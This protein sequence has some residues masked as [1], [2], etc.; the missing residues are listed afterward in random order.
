MSP[1]DND[2]VFIDY[3]AGAPTPHV[4]YAARLPL[5]GVTFC[6]SIFPPNPGV[7]LGSTQTI[8][9]VHGPPSFEMV[10]HDPERDGPRQQIVDP[11]Q[12]NINRSCLPVFHRWGVTA[13]ALIIALDDCLIARTV[14]EAFDCSPQPMRVVVG[15]SDPVI[16]EIAALSDR[17]ISNRGS[18]G[19]LYA[20]SLA[21]ALIIHLFRSYGMKPDP[22]RLVR[23]GLPAVQLRR[24]RDYVDAHLGE[25][26]GLGELAAL[27]G[28]SPHHFGQAFKASTGQPPHQYVIDRRVQRAKDLLIAGNLSIAEIAL[29]VGFSNQ[30]HMTFNFRKRIGTTPAHYRRDLGRTSI[31]ILPAVGR[32]GLSPGEDLASPDGQPVLT[33]ANV[34]CP[35]DTDQ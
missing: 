5:G 22:L 1:N 18:F 7:T 21:T 30:S 26:I 9:A 33:C 27:A 16:Q 28:L 34:R 19:R 13:K 10:W 25:D 32:P 23:G 6:R 3:S 24:I 8:V 12:T 2:T 35:S 14:S 20:E 15:V 11:G 17:E 31:A 4:T 29:C